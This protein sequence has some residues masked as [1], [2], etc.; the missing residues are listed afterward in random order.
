MS[1]SLVWWD[2]SL[3]HED[4]SPSIADVM[5]V[6]GQLNGKNRS[7]ITLYAGDRHLSVGGDVST[8]LVLYVSPDGTSFYQL[9]DGSERRDLAQV[10]AGGQAAHYESRLLLGLPLVRQAVEEF[11]SGS[12][13][14]PV[15]AW[16][17][18]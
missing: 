6:V 11:F 15:L 8:G 2:S 18:T 14:S 4:Q 13:V 3:E 9:S 7:L 10:V 5:M 16:L 12:A 1:V 17:R